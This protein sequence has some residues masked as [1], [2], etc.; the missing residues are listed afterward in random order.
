MIIRGCHLRVLWHPGKYLFAELLLSAVSSP[1]IEL[2]A[3]PLSNFYRR[4]YVSS[5]L[6]MMARLQEVFYVLP[7]VLRNLIHPPSPI[8]CRL[9]MCRLDLL[10]R[11]PLKRSRGG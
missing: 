6:V 11:T 8:T 4:I 7:L 10:G 3:D 5:S 2:C 9:L 1:D